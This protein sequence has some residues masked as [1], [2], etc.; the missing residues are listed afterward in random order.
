MAYFYI[1]SESRVTQF[2]QATYDAWVAAGNPKANYYVP[3]PDPPG[4]GY[5]YDGTQWVAPP[6]YI[7]QQV[8]RFQALAAL[9]NAGLLTQAQAIIDDPA[10]P[11]IS[12]LAWANALH[13]ERTSPTLIALAGALGLSDSDLDNL[14]IEASQ[15]TA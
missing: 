12:K 4:P 8:T 10:T 5:T 13:F 1:Q 7:P 11:E 9:S 6:V 2:D 3:I 14:F 15:I